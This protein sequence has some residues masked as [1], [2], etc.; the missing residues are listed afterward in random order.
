MG[1]STGTDM[2]DE[3]AVRKMNTLMMMKKSGFVES[4]EYAIRKKSIMDDAGLGSV[5]GHAKPSVNKRKRMQVEDDEDSSDSDLGSE[6]VAS[7]KTGGSRGAGSEEQRVR[8]RRLKRKASVNEKM[9]KVKTAVWVH[10]EDEKISKLDVAFSFK[11]KDGNMM[12]Q[13]KANADGTWSCALCHEKTKGCKYDPEKDLRFD[14][15]M[16]HNRYK[17]HT[18]ALMKQLALPEGA[19][20]FVPWLKD[21]L[22]YEQS[23][24]AYRSMDASE[25]NGNCILIYCFSVLIIALTLP[26]RR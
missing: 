22:K 15:K 4:P 9:Q 19:I 20:R 8:E 13:W 26:F 23:V 7:S 18:I 11:T 16:E 3:D 25:R 5:D 24:H 2:I 14:S 12:D 1:G 10:C 17:K 21:D 6:A